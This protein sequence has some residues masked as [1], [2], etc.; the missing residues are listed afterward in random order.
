M[1]LTPYLVL[2]GD[3]TVR[4]NSLTVPSIVAPTYAPAGQHLVSVVVIGPMDA[5][6]ESVERSVRKKLTGWFGPAVGDW[7]HL[8][9]Y[10]LRHALPEQPPPMPDPSVAASPIRPGLF[11][12]GEYG[13]VP[14]IQWSMLSGRQA[15]EAVLK[16]LVIVLQ[17]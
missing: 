5:D 16:E 14:G 6:D 10:R 3:G 8:K 17:D 11:V 15:A 4:V 9:T 13:S 12:C 1:S 2:N 7:R